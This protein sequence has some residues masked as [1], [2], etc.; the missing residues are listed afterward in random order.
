MLASIAAVCLLTACED[1]FEDGSMQPDGSSPS[2]TIKNPTQNQTITPTQGLQV[3]ITVVDKDEVD[4]INFS[5]QSPGAE[6]PLVDFDMMPHKTVVEFDTLMSLEG[7]VPG[8]YTLKI[9]AKDKRT[10]LSEKEISF[11]V[12]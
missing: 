1:L 3:Y 4:N 2:L 10:N 5:V 9:T 12:Q 7:I 8:S 6:S 11:T